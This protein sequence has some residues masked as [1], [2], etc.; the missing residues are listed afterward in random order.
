VVL[1]PTGRGGIV[2]TKVTHPDTLGLCPYKAVTIRRCFRRFVRCADHFLRSHP[3]AFPG[4]W[5][6]I[7]PRV[8]VD[9]SNTYGA[10]NHRE[11]CS[12]RLNDDIYLHAR[13][14]NPES[15]IFFP[16]TP[17]IDVCGLIDAPRSQYIAMIGPKRAHIYVH[18]PDL[19]QSHP[20][21]RLRCDACS[22]LSYKMR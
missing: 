12:N 21:T 22:V 18:S 15:R 5:D 13:P 17:N 6:Y 4:A 7:S 3:S 11:P 20:L 10:I 9:Q 14:D 2:F 19:R 16:T 1:D 8:V